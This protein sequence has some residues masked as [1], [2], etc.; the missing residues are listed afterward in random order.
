MTVY[1]T[2]IKFHD[3]KNLKPIFALKYSNYVHIAYIR[4]LSSAKASVRSN[5]HVTHVYLFYESI[6]KIITS[7]QYRDYV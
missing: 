2:S 7:A 5:S 6:S 1:E 3:K 4:T